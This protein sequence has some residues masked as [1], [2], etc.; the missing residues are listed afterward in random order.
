[1][2]PK[3]LIVDDDQ[4]LRKV[5]EYNLAQEGYEVFSAASGREGLALIQREEP[6]LCI[7]DIQL[8]DMSGM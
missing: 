6:E 2:K 1:M 3:I 4:S 8:G 7:L 5:L